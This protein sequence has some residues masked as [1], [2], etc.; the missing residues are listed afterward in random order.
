MVSVDT[1][2]VTS[3][4]P[5]QTATADQPAL[6]ETVQLHD[7]LEGK[8]VEAA[9]LHAQN[10]ELRHV[11][12]TQNHVIRSLRAALGQRIVETSRNEL[13][14]LEHSAGTLKTV[15][16]GLKLVDDD[17]ASVEVDRYHDDSDTEIESMTSNPDS[18]DITRT[19]FK[20]TTSA[21]EM[22]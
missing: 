21:S 6:V 1:T 18:I 4:M 8:T 7:F 5:Q 22:E 20:D 11:V 13:L 16:D 14:N 19:S 3:A 9:D 2:T 17:N 12:E 10:A 15:I